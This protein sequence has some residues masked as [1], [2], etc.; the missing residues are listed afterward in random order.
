MFRMRPILGLSAL[1]IVLGPSGLLAGPQDAKSH[2]GCVDINWSKAVGD[3]EP[4]VQVSLEPA[5]LKLMASAG[6]EVDPDVVELVKDLSYVRVIMYEDLSDGTS[7]VT[8]V[9][10]T[11]VEALQ[12]DGWSPVVKVRED[13]EET[14][15]VLMKVDGETIVGFVIFVAEPDELVF[16]NIAGTMDP[17]IFGPKLGAVV[18]KLSGGDLELGDLNGLLESVRT[19]N[20]DGDGS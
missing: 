1:L 9:V 8:E 20:E 2:P 6:E 11:Q 16:V 17:E 3:K 4:S 15:D 14:V 7:D 13:E 19:T 10:V 18:G 12:D 5:L